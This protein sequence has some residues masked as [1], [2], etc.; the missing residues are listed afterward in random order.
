LPRIAFAG[1]LCEAAR[2]SRG[3]EI[4]HQQG[5][6]RVSPRARSLASRRCPYGAWG[7]APYTAPRPAPAKLRRVAVRAK[8][9]SVRSKADCARGLARPYSDDENCRQET[10]AE[11]RS[12]AHPAKARNGPSSPPKPPAEKASKTRLILG[13]FSP[14]P[15]FLYFPATKRSGT[16]RP[17]VESPKNGRGP[18]C[19]STRWSNRLTIPKA[20]LASS[21]HNQAPS[22][23]LWKRFCAIR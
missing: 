2:D 17:Q 11:E 23:A 15:Y 13:P 6:G 18:S 22:R 7:H 9:D 4:G 20:I 8:P 14:D 21:V 10:K 5:V 1:R 19:P 16:W 3:C 12:T